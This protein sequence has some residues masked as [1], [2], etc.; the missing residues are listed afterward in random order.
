M[1]ENCWPRKFLAKG[2]IVQ[3]DFD[4]D[5]VPMP[6]CSDIKLVRLL[7]NMV[8][9]YYALVPFLELNEHGKVECTTLGEAFRKQCAIWWPAPPGVEL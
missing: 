4:R 8:I 3:S 6:C 2:S 7:L 1:L 9:H 5:R